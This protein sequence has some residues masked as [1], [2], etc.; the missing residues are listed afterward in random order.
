MTLLVENTDE[1]FQSAAY[2]IAIEPNDAAG[3]EHTVYITFAEP[4]PPSFAIRIGEALYQLR[5]ALDH[6][7][8]LL[9]DVPPT[10]RETEFVITDNADSFYGRNGKRALSTR[11]SKIRS[12]EA[13]SFIEAVQ[14]FR[15]SKGAA[16]SP[17]WVLHELFMADKHRRLLLTQA[18][19]HGSRRIPI[20]PGVRNIR[21]VSGALKPD[22]SGRAVLATL[23]LLEPRPRIDLDIRPMLTV[24]FAGEPVATDRIVFDVLEEAHQFTG[25]V[26]GQLAQ[27]L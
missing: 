25:F 13:R 1:Y 16:N 23:T 11:L 6:A 21:F 10:S 12:P 24:A 26:V 27:F 2:S 15:A 5:S 22:A 14:P 8:M 19:S 7:V 20:Y 3:L 9:S 18:G 17:L 4:L